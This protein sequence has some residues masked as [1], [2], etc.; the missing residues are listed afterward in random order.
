MR[1]KARWWW[2]APVVLVVLALSGGV[3]AAADR[4]KVDQATRQ[5]EDGARQIGQ[6]RIGHGFK[7]L[8]TG[9]GRTVVEG[10]KFSGET[11]KEFF[12]K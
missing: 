7:H 6:G 1:S 12:R 4:S 5:V 10:V 9:I 8:F 2:I 11:V 3:A